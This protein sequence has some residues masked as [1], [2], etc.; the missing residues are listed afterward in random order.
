MTLA[1]ELVEQVRRRASFACEYCGVTETDSGGALTV[2][3]YHPK[4]H[5][6]SDD[7]ANLLYCC[8]RCNLY[9]AGYWPKQ[10]TDPVLWNPRQDPAA[11]HFFPGPDGVLQPLT[12]TGT[13]T[14]GRLHLN[15]PPLV[16]HRLRR[17]QDA[18][19]RRM[20]RRHREQLAAEDRLFEQLISALEEHRA[21]LAEQQVLLDL[22]LRD[23]W[24][25]G[26][27]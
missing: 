26:R 1:T 24:G 17:R 7:L 18:E 6:G 19:Y 10:P 15:R 25:S 23:S 13:F 5:G 12:P 9:K 8:Y 14:L 11:T 3:H 20:L 4:V 21:F 27:G 2:D 22:L 16:A